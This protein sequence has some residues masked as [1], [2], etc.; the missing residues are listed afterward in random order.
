M[1]YWIGFDWV[2]ER[3]EMSA[4]SNSILEVINIE[5]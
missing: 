3:R 5:I 2:E 4:A 1:N